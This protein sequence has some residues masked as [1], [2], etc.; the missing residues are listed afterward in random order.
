MSL[1]LNIRLQRDDSIPAFGGFLDCH[2]Q[3][4]DHD[5]VI[6][7]NVQAVCAPWLDD[8][9]GKQCPQ[10]MDDRKR[11]IVT[12]L[13]HEFGHALLAHMKLPQEEEAIEKACMDWEAAYL[14]GQEGAK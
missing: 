3:N 6:L 7:M 14:R 1:N 5:H 2:C 4:H 8:E 13:M 11:L 9:N 10:T 12:T